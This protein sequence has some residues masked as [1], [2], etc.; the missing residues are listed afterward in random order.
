MKKS[1][2]TVFILAALFSCTNNQPKHEAT[3]ETPKALQGD[4]GDTKRYS[5][6]ENDLT[7]ELYAELVGKTPKLKKLESDIAAFGPKPDELNE[8]YLVYQKLQEIDGSTFK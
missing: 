5:R 1:L 8:K 2:T 3:Q 7:E 6:P 4:L